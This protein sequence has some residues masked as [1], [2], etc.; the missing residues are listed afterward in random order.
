MGA[1]V[2]L[3]YRGLCVEGGVEFGL[4]WSGLVWSGLVWSAWVGVG[5]IMMGL[6]V[7]VLGRW[8]VEMAQGCRW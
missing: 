8:W 5:L 1:G 7:K 2:L 4:V 3:V 6:D